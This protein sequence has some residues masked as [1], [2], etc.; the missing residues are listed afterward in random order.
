[1]AGDAISMAA[2]NAILTGR[3][4]NFL[5]RAISLNDGVS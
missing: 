3:K 5:I 2:A 4:R 1:M